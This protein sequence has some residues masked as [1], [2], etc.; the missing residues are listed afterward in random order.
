MEVPLPPQ[1]HGGMPEVKPA[2]KKVKVVFVCYE[3]QESSPTGMKMFRAVAAS[4]GLAD[5]FELDYTGVYQ[6]RR[7][8]QLPDFMKSVSDADYLVPMYVTLLPEMVRLKEKL[9]LKAE[10]L[11][12][13]APTIGAQLDEDRYPPLLERIK[14]EKGIK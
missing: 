2:Q 3:G 1:G 8:N 7:P 14:R 10:I 13:G 11:D 5:R 4:Q 12:L 9:H 6:E